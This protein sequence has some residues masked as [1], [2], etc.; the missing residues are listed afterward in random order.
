MDWVLPSVLPGD[1]LGNEVHA[2]GL[3]DIDHLGEAPVDPVALGLEVHQLPVAGH[4][5]GEVITRLAGGAVHAELLAMIHP[6]EGQ[7]AAGVLLLRQAEEIGGE[8]DLGLHLLLA[9]AVIVVR[10][11]GEDDPGAVPRRDLEGVALVVALF[12][13]AP[14]HPIRALARRGVVPVGQTQLLLGQARQVRGQQ[15]AARMAGPVVHVQGGVELRQEGVAAVAED[16]LHEVQVGD[17]IP[18]GEEADLHVLLRLEAGDLRAHQGP[19]QQG[20]IHPRRLRLVGGEGD[21]HQVRGGRQGMAQ[22]AGED[23]L[24][25]RLLVPGDGQAALGDMEGPLGGAAVARRVVQHAL[26]D[27]VTGDD[28]G[29]GS[30]RCRWGPT[31]PGPGRGGRG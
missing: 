13:I 25:H 1:A 12:G 17:Q 23:R 19:Q 21:G 18:R 11:D 15:H 14:A 10:Q 20:D 4:H 24:G 9:V 6:R 3:G 7:R 30:C 28:V 26:G 31:A 27:A 2:Q 8:A 16:A 22:Q 29:A 5:V